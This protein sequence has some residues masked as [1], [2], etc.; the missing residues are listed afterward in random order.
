MGFLAR[1]FN[2]V[3]KA[4][5]NG[6]SLD[7]KI[8]QWK[9]SAT[10][11]L[12]SLMRALAKLIPEGSTLYLEGGTP[13]K[14]L[15]RFFEERSVPERSHIAMGTIWPWPRVFHLP[16]THENLLQLA[17]LAE[18]SAL[19]E[20]AIHLHVYQDDRVLL[21]WHDAFFDPFYISKEIPEDKVRTFCDGLSIQY[22]NATEGGE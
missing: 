19:P 21:Q 3:P 14:E 16:A 13:G 8:P 12:S 5:R 2:S 22:E 1:L 15:L 4:E 7:Y 11:N 6:I 18:R 17:D 20:V 10:K 9:V